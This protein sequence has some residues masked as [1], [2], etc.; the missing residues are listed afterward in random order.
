M[1]NYKSILKKVKTHVKSEL[2]KESSGHGFWHSKRVAE[3][4][5]MIGK[6][7]KAD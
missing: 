7:E 6:K 1:K 3:M 5:L 2:A 4:A